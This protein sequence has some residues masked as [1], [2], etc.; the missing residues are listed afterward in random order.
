MTCVVLDV[1]SCLHRTGDGDCAIRAIMFAM[2]E[3]AYYGSSALVVSMMIT[4]TSAYT[5]LSGQ[6]CTPAV[7]LGYETFMVRSACLFAWDGLDNSALGK[8]A[9]ALNSLVTLN[10]L[11]TPSS[12]LC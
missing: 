8:A 5:M 6:C 3:Q 4:L 7:E 11:K 10:A 2:L 1:T 9:V 12:S